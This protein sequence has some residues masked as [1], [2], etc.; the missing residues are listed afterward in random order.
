MAW[1]IHPSLP[2]PTGSFT[3]VELVGVGGAVSVEVDDP[4]M[5]PYPHRCVNPSSLRMV[6]SSCSASAVDGL[7]IDLRCTL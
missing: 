1:C 2:G 5:R 7:S 3:P 6:G 4:C